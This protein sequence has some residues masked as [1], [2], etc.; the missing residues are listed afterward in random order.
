MI[1]DREQ[2]KTVIPHR[3]PF[4]LIDT[5]ESLDETTVTG[6]KHVTGNEDWFAGHFPEEPVMPGVLI[7][8]CIAQTGAVLLL[9]K[10]EYKG[11]IA[12]F[13]RMDKV[14]F[15]RKVVPGDLLETAV[16]VTQIRGNAGRAK[17]QAYVDG[18]LAVSL[19]LTFAIGEAPEK[20]EL[21]VP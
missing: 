17:G 12:Y 11:R 14:R 1:L 10:P 15:R 13:G 20:D 9:S 6:T 2:I 21:H 8:E 19:E 3:D 18:E 5:I 16:E 4:L 7:C